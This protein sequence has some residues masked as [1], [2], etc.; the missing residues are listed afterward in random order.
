MA[1]LW[2]SFFGQ[3][4]GEKEQET[5]TES[6]KEKEKE[7]EEDEEVI[8]YSPSRVLSV[9]SYKASFILFFLFILLF[10]L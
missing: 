10:F 5:E 2:K 4:D 9:K 8:P 1:S 7:K 3:D 6:E